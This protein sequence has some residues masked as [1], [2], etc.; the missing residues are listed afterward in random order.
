MACAC[1]VVQ[2]WPGRSARAH[3]RPSAQRQRERER[4]GLLAVHP[5]QLEAGSRGVLVDL[6]AGAAQVVAV[7]AR[8][9][10]EPREPHLGVAGGELGLAADGGVLRLALA[11][12]LGL[13]EAVAQLAV[14]A[15]AGDG[16]LDLPGRALGGDRLERDRDRPDR[17]RAPEQRVH[18]HRR[19]LDAR[20]AADP[21]GGVD[22]AVAAVVL[23]V[24]ARAERP[25][26]GFGEAVAAG[27]G[28]LERR[29]LGAGVRVE[30]GAQRPRELARAERAEHR[31]LGR[32]EPLRDPLGLLDQRAHRGARAR[33]RRPAV[34]R[35]GPRSGPRAPASTRVVVPISSR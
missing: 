4:L 33:G 5:V 29:E 13:A 8:D 19:D 32:L 6:G 28:G 18:E 21:E 26:V 27:F 14:G 2:R 31:H 11:G 1:R 20:P 17:A 34:R 7:P 12:G 22:G 3:R 16:G 23:P 30:R 9:R 35:S 10:H 25:R 24:L 15:V